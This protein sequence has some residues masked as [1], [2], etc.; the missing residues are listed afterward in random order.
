MGAGG[1]GVALIGEEKL[2]VPFGVTG[3]VLDV[4]LVD[5][6]AKYKTA[7]INE[8]IEPSVHRAE[9]ICQHFGVC[10]GCRLQHINS[11]FYKKF[12]KKHVETT[13]Q[14]RGFENLEIGDV[15]ISP[16]RSRRRARFNA[17]KI[18]GKLTL[19]LSEKAQHKLFDLKECPVMKDEITELVPSL[20]RFLNKILKNQDKMAI[21]VT[22]CEN[23]LDVVFESKG[24]PDL[25][26]RME[27]ASFAE[28]NDIARISW[29]DN[30]LKKPQYERLCERRK[31]FVRFGS[32][33]V[34]TPPG[35]F[36]QATKEGEAALSRIALSFL[37]NCENIV[38]IFAGCGTFGVAALSRLNVHAVEYSVEM[39]NALR[40][41]ANLLKGTKKLTTEIRDLYLRP[42][43]EFELNEFDGAIIDPPRAGAK[44]QV[45]EVI[46]SSITKIV[47]ISCNPA[48]FARDARMLVDAGF[49]MGTVTPV[50]QFLYSPHLEII[51][52][53]ERK[54]AKT[55]DNFIGW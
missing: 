11:E 20:R 34:M 51:A 39:T 43:N 3:D 48:T 45:E 54:H 46:R 52:C 33:K 7:K 53:F 13:L 50:D 37:K 8:I 6:K 17:V 1:D 26:L 41:S 24:E 28:L 42:L 23:G 44:A 29:F 9:P 16:L 49:K 47:M 30:G 15:K 21:Q 36:L 55:F 2:F 38:D 10:G 4:T 18:K 5:E 25:D 12:Q 19:G 40:D 27:I 32:R 22:L 31:P 14:H 35:S